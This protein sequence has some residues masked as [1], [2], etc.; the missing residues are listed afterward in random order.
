MGKLIDL[1]GQK[2]GRLTV[3]EQA[4][5]RK[6][7]I[8]WRCVCDCGNANFVNGRKLRDNIIKSCGCYKSQ[9]FKKRVSKHSL[10]KTKIYKLYH[11]IKRRCYDKNDSHY[12]CYGGRG[13]KMCEEWLNNFSSFY[14]WAMSNGYKE[15]ILPNGK[16]KW[17]I[18]RIDVNGNYEP[19]N[20]RWTTIQEQ[21][22]N[23]RTNIYLT[24]NGETLTQNEWAKKLDIYAGA[25]QW[26]LKKGWSVEEALST[27]V[28]YGQRIKK[29]RKENN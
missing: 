28:K 10:S 29:F 3:I 15:E 8:Y 24:Y 5:V 22:K 23:K 4:Y 7:I 14:D 21:A 17:T 13:I 12:N 16:N 25:I 11:L 27:P 19:N 9:E 2:F 26:R 6:G 20:C 18:D 1:T